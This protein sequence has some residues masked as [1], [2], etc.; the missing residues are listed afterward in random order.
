MDF[1][2]YC[3]KSQHLLTW[4]AKLTFILEYGVNRRWSR[5][6]FGHSL[7]PGVLAH[8]RI[9]FQCVS[10]ILEGHFSMIKGKLIQRFNYIPQYV[11][12]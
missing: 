2:I 11:Q 7:T 5:V 3:Y 1:L 12:Y 10:M 8:T 9:G 6:S 4:A